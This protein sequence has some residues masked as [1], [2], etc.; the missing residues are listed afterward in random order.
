MTVAENGNV[1][2]VDERDELLQA[3]ERDEEDVREALHEL[4]NA[5]EQKLDV[6]ER[7]RR[8]PLA[9]TAGATLVG[10]IWGAREASAAARDRRWMMTTTQHSTENRIMDQLQPVADQVSSKLSE[11]GSRISE[12]SSKMDLGPKLSQIEEE[13]RAMVRQQP[14]V[15]VLAALGVGY[16]IARLAS[17]RMSMR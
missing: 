2:F 8:S 11:A 7:I 4:T 17:G 16:L 6:S 3:I 5:A 9:W 15:A 13:T 12:M 10:A 1:D 14:L